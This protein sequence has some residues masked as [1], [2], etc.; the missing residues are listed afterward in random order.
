MEST[1]RSTSPVT[2]QSS[3]AR[4][5][6]TVWR[7]LNTVLMMG[8]GI[9]KSYY[10]T[11]GS[12]TSDWII[13]IGWAVIAYWGMYVEGEAPTLAPWFFIRDF[14]RP[15]W[16]VLAEA[17]TMASIVGAP[18]FAC[19]WV[20]PNRDKPADRAV[21]TFLWILSVASALY[22]PIQFW[23]QMR[24]S[25]IITWIR[26]RWMPRQFNDSDLAGMFILSKWVAGLGNVGQIVYNLYHFTRSSNPAPSFMFLWLLTTGISFAFPLVICG[27]YLAVHQRS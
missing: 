3:G 13:S 8:F 9:Y 11:L 17:S 21:T 4:L 10:T 19:L 7:L 1:T 20:F 27:V 12:P 22:A 2:S 6:V 5:K 18:V 23:D 25:R 26:R 24:N 14:S 16:F 15:T